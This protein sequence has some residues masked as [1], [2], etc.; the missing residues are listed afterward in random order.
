MEY[1]FYAEVADWLTERC[2]T[3]DRV[4]LHIQELSDICSPHELEA[5]RSRLCGDQSSEW[6]K[7]WAEFVDLMSSGDELWRYSSPQESWDQ[8]M[9]SAGFAIVRAGRV[10]HVRQ[11]RT[12]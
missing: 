11:T 5:E 2:S 3:T 12:N 1:D 4:A 7:E 9:G 8:G 6:A 10:I